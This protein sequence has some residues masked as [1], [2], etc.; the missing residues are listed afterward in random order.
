MVKKVVRQGRSERRGEAYPGPYV[1][2]LSDAR[3]KLTAL[4]SILLQIIIRFTDRCKLIASFPEF[5]LQ[6][7]LDE[8]I[9]VAIHDG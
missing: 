9:E 2:S 3:T 1:E 5:L 8:S 4:F 6:I 7:G